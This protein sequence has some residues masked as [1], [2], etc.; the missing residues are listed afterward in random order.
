MYEPPDESR[1]VRAVASLPGTTREQFPPELVPNVRVKWRDP[2]SFASPATSS[3]I[4]GGDCDGRV[5]KREGGKWGRVGPPNQEEA[6]NRRRD[7]EY[8]GGARKQHT[9]GVGIARG[10]EPASLDGGGVS[11]EE[12]S[13]TPS[14]L[15]G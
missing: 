11:T 1:S 12:E 15:S 7:I 14:Q 6:L 13:N 4:D 9:E 5:G 2:R 10:S 8:T 3:L